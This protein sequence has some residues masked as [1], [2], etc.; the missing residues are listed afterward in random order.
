MYFGAQMNGWLE[1]S[2][3]NGKSACEQDSNPKTL[4]LG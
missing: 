3:P 2:E 4:K 1:T